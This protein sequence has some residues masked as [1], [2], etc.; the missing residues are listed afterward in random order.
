[1]S[2]SDKARELIAQSA[3]L[4]T[5]LGATDAADAETKIYLDFQEIEEDG[6]VKRPSVIVRPISHTSVR[7]GVDRGMVRIRIEDLTES[8]TSLDDFRDSINAIVKESETASYDGGG[9]ICVSRGGITLESV[10]LSLPSEEEE[11][12]EYY[13]ASIL[14]AHG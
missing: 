2:A 3:T 9:R 5:M 12:E 1:M 10:D 13:V 14:L 11:Q 8:Y 7:G 6:K 4:Q